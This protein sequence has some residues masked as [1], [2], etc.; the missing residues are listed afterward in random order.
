MKI[1]NQFLIKA[2]RL[3]YRVWRKINLR[4]SNPRLWSN[5][6]IKKIAPLFSENVINVSGGRD[7]DKEGGTYRDYFR[8]AKSYTLSNY[9]LEFQGSTSYQEIELDLSAPIS[10]GSTLMKKYETVFSHTVLEHIYK[11]DQAIENL[12]RLSSDI[13]ITVVPFLQEFHHVPGQYLDYWRISPHSLV[14]SFEKQGFYTLYVNWND[15]PFGNIYIFHVAS[16]KPEKWKDKIRPVI[17]T[18][19]PGSA[20]L[21]LHPEQE[22]SVDR[23]FVNFNDLYKRK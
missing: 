12:C 18:H 9:I 10:D 16:C 6:E 17:M 1:L 4:Q 21:M 8:S 19:G 20:R 5:D 14:L 2:L 11:V 3:F 23:V 13:V 15:D 7:N 22:Y